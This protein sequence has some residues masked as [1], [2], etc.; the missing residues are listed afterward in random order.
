MMRCPEVHKKD[1]FLLKV[2]K[3]DE[4]S[5]DSSSKKGKN[6]RPID[7]WIYYEVK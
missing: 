1:K 4:Y 3:V 2:H 5:Y 7:G 6:N